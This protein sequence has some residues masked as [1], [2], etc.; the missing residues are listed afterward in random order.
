MNRTPRIWFNGKLRESAECTVHIASHA[1][2]YGSSVFEGIRA[3]D[4]PAGTM[5]MRG[6]DHMK[7]LEY[8]ARV[9]R[10]PMDYSVDELHDAMR[11]TVRDSELASAYIRPIIS[12]GNCGLGV[13]PKD[14]SVVDTAIMVAPWG[15]YLGEDGVKNGIKACIT[16][17]SRLA[18]N[19]MPP[20]VKA[21]GNYLSSQL[22]GLE[23]R[24][25]GFTEGIGLGVD[26]LLS[27][28]AGENIFLVKKGCLITPPASAMILSGITRDAVI[29]LAAE[30]GIETIEQTISREQMYA[31][32][33]IFMTGTAAEV[34]PV[35]QVDHMV[36]G[37]GGC[38]PVTRQ[39]QEAYFGLFNG[40]TEDRWGWLE[41]ID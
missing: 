22:I 14:M 40:Q 6:T 37:N 33:E 20:G 23:A 15:A 2:H 5:I 9:Y 41:P 35:R 21:G 10:M 26:G 25:R 4:T 29:T 18:P 8:S 17:W 36:I 31:A 12:R 16:S 34:T 7:R 38:G 13:I 19:T 30:T 24:D 11:E 28:G 32:D 1:L 39:L 3:Y 27:E